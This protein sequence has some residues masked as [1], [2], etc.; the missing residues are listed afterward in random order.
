MRNYPKGSTKRMSDSEMRR[1]LDST[2]PLPRIPPQTGLAVVRVSPPK[3]RLIKPWVPPAGHLPLVPGQQNGVSLPRHDRKLTGIMSNSLNHNQEREFKKPM[4]LLE[5]IKLLEAKSK[6]V[7]GEKD[8]N[9]NPVLLKKIPRDK[10]LKSSQRKQEDF[11]LIIKVSTPKSGKKLLDS[12]FL[13]LDEISP[14]DVSSRNGL[15]PFNPELTSVVNELNKSFASPRDESLEIVHSI[16]GSNSFTLKSPT[17]LLEP[18]K[19]NNCLVPPLDLSL[20]C[21]DNNTTELRKAEEDLFI[22]VLDDSERE[23]YSQTKIIRP[24]WV[25]RLDLS[26]LEDG[27][28]KTSKRIKKNKESGQVSYKEPSSLK[29]STR[30]LI[31][32]CDLDIKEHLELL[33]KSSKNDNIYNIPKSVPKMP[34]FFE[35]SSVP[36]KITPRE[37]PVPI[38]CSIKQTAPS[39]PTNSKLRNKMAGTSILPDLVKNRCNMKKTTTLAPN[40]KTEKKI[41]VQPPKPAE[42]HPKSRNVKLYPLRKKQ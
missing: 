3:P 4:G 31:P 37:A 12:V 15:G 39:R 28:V 23:K 34:F 22:S 17:L 26:L 6:D 11:D 41:A 9:K 29:A 21:D 7:S 13:F 25:P 14:T 32:L 24:K 10:L 1:I 33:A 20:L 30:F 36:T 27:R 40:S 18:L 35:T 38:I 19:T 16:S 42:L 2:L 5:R 8:K